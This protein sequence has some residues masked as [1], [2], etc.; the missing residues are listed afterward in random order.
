MPY[1]DNLTP[2]QCILTTKRDAIAEA[3]EMCGHVHGAR[4]D[5]ETL[6]QTIAQTI[7]QNVA[8]FYAD[9]IDWQTFTTRQC[10]AWDEVTAGAPSLFAKVHEALRTSGQP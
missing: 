1:L 7:T 9:R 4:A 8:D 10:A 6:A 3:L 5:L 2:H